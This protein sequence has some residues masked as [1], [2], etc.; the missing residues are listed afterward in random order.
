MK[1]LLNTGA[2]DPDSKYRR[3]WYGIIFAIVLWNAFIIPLRISFQLLWATLDSAWIYTLDYIGDLFFLVDIWLNFRTTYMHQGLV[4][5]NPKLMAQNYIRN[6]FFLDLIA[7]LPID[8]FCWIV[9]EH[10]VLRIPK[11][12]RLSKSWVLVQQKVTLPPTDSITVVLWL[13]ATPLKGQ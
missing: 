7:S 13:L 8:L 10:A 4:I 6:W 11:L 5:S 2:L 12:I 3:V 9:W 1:E